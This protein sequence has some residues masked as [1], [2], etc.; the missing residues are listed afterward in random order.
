MLEINE[1]MHKIWKRQ[2]EEKPSQSSIS[3]W[4]MNLP[5]DIKVKEWLA[6]EE[7]YKQEMQFK[8]ILPAVADN[9]LVGQQVG[10]RGASILCFD[11]IQVSL[12]YDVQWCCEILLEFTWWGNLW[13]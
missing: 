2:V 9:F 1:H 8:Y 7:Q 6:G 10:E 12:S 3:N 5:F 11:E 13:I 4:I